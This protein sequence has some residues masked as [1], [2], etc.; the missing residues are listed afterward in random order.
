MKPALVLTLLAL[1]GAAAVVW[2][3]ARMN[4]V[5]AIA[6][7]PPQGELLNIDGHQV[8]AVV[9]GDGPALVLIHGSSG[10][11][12]DYTFALAGRLAKTYRVISFDRPGLG[13][14]DPISPTGAT[15]AQQADILAKAAAALG[16]PKPVVLGHSYGGAVALAWAV[17]HPDAL[18]GLVLVGAPSQPWDTPLEGTYQQ[19]SNPVIGPP[20]AALATAFVG[21]ARVNTA[22]EEIFAPQTPPVGYGD[23]VGAELTLRRASLRHNAMQRANLLDEITA[24]Q[25]RYGEISVP[26]ELVHG[27]ADTTVGLKI[28]AIPFLGQVPQANLTPLDGIGHMPQHAAPDAVIAAIDRASGR[29]AR[30]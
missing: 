18:A 19:L 5:R 15:I 10:N 2:V 3:K 7:Y 26:V 16:A 24:L 30:Q 28:H 14:S 8:H 29:L 6:A 20:M 27:T 25:P 13:Y 21:P 17:H 22:L 23:Y 11:A 4:E 12:R 9:Q 1:I